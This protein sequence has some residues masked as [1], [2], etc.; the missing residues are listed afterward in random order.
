MGLGTRQ[1]PRGTKLTIPYNWLFPKCVAAIH[2]GG[3]GSTAAALHA[4]IPQII[5]PFM[6]DQFYWADK[7]FWL[8]VA[9]EP[10]RRNHLVPEHI[11]NT[12]IRDAANVLSQAIH[13]ALSPRIKARALDLSK[14]ISPEDGV[15]E[16][17]KTLREEIG[18]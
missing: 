2:H 8:G 15:S 18:C 9:P 7:M 12:I 13:D 1:S 10:L 5:C 3:S 16:A 4:G 11:S 14:R 17:V 6:L